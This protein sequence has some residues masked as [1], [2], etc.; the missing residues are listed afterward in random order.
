MHSK[1]EVSAVDEANSFW[2]PT[3]L[4][5]QETNRLTAQAFEALS[6][7]QRQTMMFFFD[8]LDFKE[9]A[10][11]IAPPFPSICISAVELICPNQRV[12]RCD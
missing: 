9:I 10:R 7:A 8:G 5:P 3:R 1:T 11:P 6:D 4:Q 12:L 2:S